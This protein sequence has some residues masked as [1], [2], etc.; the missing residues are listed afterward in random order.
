[1]GVNKGEVMHTLDIVVLLV[2]VAGAGTYGFVLVW[3]KMKN[4]HKRKK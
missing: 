4:G 3:N 1:M 2:A